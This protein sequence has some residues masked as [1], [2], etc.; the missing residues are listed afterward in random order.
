MRLRDK[1]AVVTGAGSGIGRGIALAYAQ[2]GASVV[3]VDN[4]PDGGEDTV[5]AIEEAGGNAVFIR[6]DVSRANE[7]AQLHAQVKEKFGA[8]DIVVNNAGILRTGPLHEMSEDEWDRVQGIDLKSVFLSAKQFIPEMLQR[9]KGKIIN[10]ASIAGII[11][12]EGIGAY[13]AAKGG[14]IALTREMAVEYAPHGINVNCIAPGVV[15]TAMTKDMLS[16]ATGEAQFEAVTPYPR[17]GEP[18]DIAAAAVYLASEESDFV[19][20]EVLVVDGGMSV[21]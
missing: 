10:I 8:V 11:G 7:L 18:S 4:S 17:L 12:F 16:S 6:A 1:V 15:R 2:E 5:R 21:Q 9:G 13:S 3:V 19:N 14:Q 20:G